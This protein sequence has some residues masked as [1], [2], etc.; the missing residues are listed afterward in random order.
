MTSNLDS[1]AVSVGF[2]ASGY[3]AV[4]EVARYEPE[5]KVAAE[6]FVECY[7]VP[8]RW[9]LSYSCCKQRRII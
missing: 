9:P 2:G 5:L 7:A 4:T 3:P 1:V 8:G 6:S